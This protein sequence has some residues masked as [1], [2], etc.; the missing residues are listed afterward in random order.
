MKILG[1]GLSKTGTSSL[2][3]AL[4]IL[5]FYGLHFDRDRLNDILSGK[6]QQPNFRCYD[7]V[8]VVTDL[9]SAYFYQELAEAYPDSKLILTVRE[10]EAWWKSVEFH[11]NTRFPVPVS[12]GVRAQLAEILQL[13]RWLKTDLWRESDYQKFRRNLRNCVYG[14]AVATEFLYK[15]KYLDHNARV[16][17]EIPPDR[18]LVMN[19]PAG[20]GWEKLCPF[21]GVPIPDE[22]FPHTYKTEYTAPARSR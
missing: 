19:I 17:S 22:P 2:H 8:D 15:K 18:L 5:G 3:S 20:D 13:Q 12:T 10:L 11:I 16:M 21:L 7:D 4:Q 1:V 6:V 14:S 9:P